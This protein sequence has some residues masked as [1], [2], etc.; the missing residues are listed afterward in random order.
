MLRGRRGATLGVVAAR[1]AMLR[2][3]RQAA[4]SKTGRA[5][6]NPPAP[7]RFGCRILC[8]PWAW[9]SFSP[10]SDV[11]VPHRLQPGALPPR[12]RGSVPHLQP[13]PVGRARNI[14]AR[15]RILNRY[16]PA[17]ESVLPT[18]RAIASVRRHRAGRLTG[19]SGPRKMVPPL[20][21]EKG[22]QGRKERCGSRPSNPISP[23]RSPTTPRRSAP[24]GWFSPPANFR[25]TSRPGSRPR[26]G[27]IRR[28]PIT[29]PTSRSAR[30]TC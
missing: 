8:L 24:A 22:R 2:P 6:H 17:S 5:E 9:P 7:G 14:V 25:A 20:L 27:P 13:I 28:F 23:S 30:T 11:S 29:V 18:D 15:R 12:H 10:N 26:R 21:R 4:P 1:S 16:P 19:P 3:G